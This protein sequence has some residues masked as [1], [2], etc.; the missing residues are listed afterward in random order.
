M[1]RDKNVHLDPQRIT[2]SLID[3]QDLTMH[4]RDHLEH[5]PECC[6]ARRLLAGRLDS[7][8]EQALRF[9]PV[10]RMKVRLPALEP[11][12]PS[13]WLIRWPTGAVAA[14]ASLALVSA[15]VLP[16]FFTRT[17]PHGTRVDIAREMAQDERFIAEVRQL[18][19][20][21]FASAY[22]EILPSSDST[23]DDDAFDYMDPMETMSNG[24]QDLMDI[25]GETI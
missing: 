5:C 4:E 7:L 6:E 17:I 11:V 15:L 25:Q 24:S 18:E 10:S 13:T 3:E 16:Q 23:M 20:N 19:E 21:P 14:L 9:T 22:A 12:K 8:S 2:M 1:R